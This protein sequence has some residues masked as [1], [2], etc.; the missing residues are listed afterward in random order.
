MMRV[1]WIGLLVA[2][3]ALGQ[4]LPDREEAVKK[5]L[6]RDHTVEGA[7][8]LIDHYQLGGIRTVI[9]NLENMDASSRMSYA[10]V[11]KYLDLFRFRNDLNRS[12]Q[13]AKTDEAKAVFLML[14]ATFGQQLDPV[15]VFQPY[16]DDESLPLFVRLAAVS[17]MV[18]IQN[19]TY[20]DRFIE[21]ANEV[22]LDEPLGPVF[23]YAEM[24]M[25][26]QGFYYYL[27]ETLNPDR[28]SVKTQHGAIIAAIAMAENESGQLYEWILELHDR[29]Y[30]PMMIDRAVMVGGVDLISVMQEHKTSKKKFRDE[31]AKAAGA[32]EAMAQFR[33]KWMNTVS[34]DVYPLAPLIPEEFLGYNVP[35]PMKEFGMVKVDKDGHVELVAH[36]SPFGS[37]A[38]LKSAFTDFNT[39]PGYQDWEPVERYMFVTA[40]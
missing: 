5:L 32:A 29:D 35:S 18:Q 21:I 30:L 31:L 4:G 25:K 37:S 40:Q 7:R 22:D 1:V 6:N 36:V 15:S 8:T 13:D 27:R 19:P 3:S 20:Y 10:H 12:L 23:R 39:M 16:A 9:R 34:P 38:K 17:G 2:F 33:D 11:L 28:S 26:N 24:S 14:L